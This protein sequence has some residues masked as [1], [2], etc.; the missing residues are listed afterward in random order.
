MKNLALDKDTNDLIIEQGDLRFTQTSVEYLAQKITTRLLLFVNE[1]FLDRSDGV[2]YYERIFNSQKDPDFE[3]IRAVLLARTS[4][5]EGVAEVSKFDLE[6]DRE[7][8]TISLSI[9]AV[10]ELGNAI[11]LG[12]SI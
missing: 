9:E 1:W 11:I 6:Y 8:R 10:D 5:T 4:E 7:N 2:P 3:D 12:V